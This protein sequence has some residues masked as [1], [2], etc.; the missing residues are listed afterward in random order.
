MKNK[1]KLK[2]ITILLLIGILLVVGCVDNTKT[3]IDIPPSVTNKVNDDTSQTSDITKILNDQQQK[4][5]ASQTT[6]LTASSTAL[7]TDDADW[8]K[9]GASK[10]EQG[11]TFIIK[12]LT[13][14]NGFEVCYSESVTEN[15]KTSYYFDKDGTV[16]KMNM[17]STS[18]N[19]SSSASS[20][21]TISSN[22]STSVSTI[23]T[24]G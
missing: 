10:T 16:K 6:N 13:T 21:V 8:C 18:E 3:N 5:N 1:Y 23:A 12:G 9:P 17:T 7:I 22:G 15:S 19:G 11:K 24:T 14:L 4:T 2:K 20:S